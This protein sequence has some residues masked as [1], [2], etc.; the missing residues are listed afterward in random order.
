MTDLAYRNVVGLCDVISCSLLFLS[1][2]NKML[3][4]PNPLLFWQTKTLAKFIYLFI[5]SILIRIFYNSIWT[6]T[7]FI[8]NNLI[9]SDK[10]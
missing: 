5:F 6:F 2:D 7:H 9:D 3:S 4:I 1:H 10:N 8:Y